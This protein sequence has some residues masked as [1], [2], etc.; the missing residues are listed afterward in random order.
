MSL[1]PGRAKLAYF[2]SV[3][4]CPAVLDRAD[5]TSPL[6]HFQLLPARSASLL[7]GIA[8]SLRTN[9]GAS[10]ALEWNLHVVMLEHVHLL[11]SEPE[12]RKLSVVIKCSSRM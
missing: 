11:I 12:G 6:H 5:E 7:S 1:T 4:N 2:S 9:S 8:S 3:K 10:A